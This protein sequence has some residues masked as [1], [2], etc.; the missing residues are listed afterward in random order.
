MLT[1]DVEI[2]EYSGKIDFLNSLTH[3]V[4]A[5][6]A[7]PGFVFLLQK[8]EGLRE[9]LA[10][11]VYC[12]S[13]FAVYFVSAFYHGLPVSEAKRKAR[14]LDH[15]TVPLL[16]AGTATPCAMITLF[17]ISSFHCVL[18]M[19]CAWI[20]YIFGV[21]SKLFFF[22]KLKNITVAVYIA[23]GA[24]M[25]LSVIPILDMITKEGFNCLLIGCAFY[26]LGAMLCAMG[27]KRP[28]LHVIFHLFVLAGSAV[29]FFAMYNY[30]F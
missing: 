29:H 30:V 25:I 8:A 20:C 2:I 13:I 24:L 6:L 9:I 21:L 27:I 10:C 22:E 19:V 18:V 12:F 23:L 17:E 11:S 4:G 1:K 5:L 26:L 28:F 16:I 15:T 3:A 7:V 14:L